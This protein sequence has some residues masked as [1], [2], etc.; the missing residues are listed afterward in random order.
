VSRAAVMAYRVLLRHGDGHLPVDPLAILRKCRDLAVYT[1]E[2]AAE[3]LGMT[4]PLDENTMAV[5]WSMERDGRVYRIVCYRTEGNPARLRF[6]LAH[7]LG[8]I[9][10]RHAP[11]D[12]A[13]EREA[14]AFASHLLMPR[15]VIDMLKAEG[16]L[17]AEQV[18]ALCFVSQ[19][20][21]RML[22]GEKPILVEESLQNNVRDMFYAHLPAILP[23]GR[24]TMWWH[25]IR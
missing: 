1:Q 11:D 6:T 24:R 20:A 16:P 9:V 14:D 4:P 5:T 17:Y 25:E 10:L 13:A 19:S 15:P 21:A 8:H 2:E 23:G 12:P 7:E 22:S 3:L 18:E